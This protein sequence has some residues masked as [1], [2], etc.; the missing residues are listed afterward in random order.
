M[1]LT[2]AS[3]TSLGSQSGTFTVGETLNASGGG[4]TGATYRV[5]ATNI[6]GIVTAV[7]VLQ[8]GQGYTGAITSLTG[9]SKTLNVTANTDNF[10]L[11]GVT[12]T[13]AGSGYNGTPTYT[14]S[15]GDA[16]PGAITPSSVTL[17]SDSSIGGSGN[18]TI[19]PVISG[20]FALT[21][22]G[23]A[24]V[25]F[26][27]T[28]ANTYNGNIIINDGVLEFRSTSSQTFTIG[29]VGT[30]NAVSGPGSAFFRG[31]FNFDLAS[32]S[33]NDGDSWTIVAPAT[34]KAYD[35]GFSVT[36]FTNN[37]GVWT[38]GT[39]GVIYRFA[40]SNS[41]LSVGTNA[42]VAGYPAW[43][44]YWQTVFTNFTATATGDDPDGD[45]FKNG[46]EF[47]FDGVP[48]VGSPALLSAVKNGTNALLSWVQRNS[49]VTYTVK[50]TTNLATGG[51]TNAAVTVTNAADQSG[52]NLTNDYTRRSFTVPGT[53]NL[54]FRVEAVVP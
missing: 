14:F 37:S 27:G 53:D 24:T 28:A 9:A 26:A 38:R 46:T 50:S 39:N 29:G 35:G 23:A 44:G 21:K 33:T 4:G 15:T 11:R 36:G 51:W 47:A 5:D 10:I 6:S 18:M 32:A 13:A 48:M 41:I 42:P 43:V 49:G 2:T 40:Q 52:I 19:N 45:G 1:G 22:V 17:A 34:T 31:A 54:F 8:A 20:N 30:N 16:T 12:M 3:I 25:T 7:S